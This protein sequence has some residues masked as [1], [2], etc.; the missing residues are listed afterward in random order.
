[1]VI[2]GRLPL[3]AQRLLRSLQRGMRKNPFSLFCSLLV[4]VLES[5]SLWLLFTS[6]GLSE[7]DRY[8]S[9]I[10]QAIGTMGFTFLLPTFW[11]MPFRWR[12]GGM[13][14]E[15]ATASLDRNR[16]WRPSTGVRWIGFGVWAV[17]L[18]L[19]LVLVV[20]ALAGKQ[21]IAFAGLLL[22]VAGLNLVALIS[23]LVM[24]LLLPG[25]QQAL[26]SGNQRSADSSVVNSEGL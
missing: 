7:I 8:R 23:V 25:R 15:T 24:R 26:I 14:A 5:I 9:A 20:E 10:G 22:V 18:A 2:N 3:M 17:I 13:N 4:L 11:T 12:F 6:W 19:A 21:G 1:M 16:E